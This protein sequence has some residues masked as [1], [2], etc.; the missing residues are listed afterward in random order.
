MQGIK[1]LL[2]L[3]KKEPSLVIENMDTVQPWG[4]I[5][6]GFNPYAEITIQ[7]QT[8]KPFSFCNLYFA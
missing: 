8:K 1:D 2:E 4:I 3:F 5:L 7:I 6:S